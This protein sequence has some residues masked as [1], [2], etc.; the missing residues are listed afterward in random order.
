MKSAVLLLSAAMFGA[1][2]AQLPPVPTF[3]AAWDAD[4]AS[5]LLVSQ[6]AIPM[7]GA[8]GENLL[9][10]SEADA[11]QVQVQAQAGHKYFD[12]AHNRSRFG[13]VVVFYNLQKEVQVDASMACTAYCP[14]EGETMEPFGL[15]TASDEKPT[16]EGT[17]MIA[18]KECEHWQWKEKILG[19]ITME[20]SDFYYCA[21]PRVD[22]L[23]ARMRERT[24]CLLLTL[25]ACE[26]SYLLPLPLAPPP[27][28]PCRHRRRWKQHPGPR[29]RRDFPVR[30]APWQ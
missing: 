2:S 25:S 26:S 8:S 17:A 18:G 22:E 4:E 20:I 10:C 21:L 15:P 9:C 6:G 23:H 14:L 1:S 13:D 19:V 27:P 16:Y 24:L 30:T 3:P 11:C 29:N 12:L 5:D 7:T 28:P